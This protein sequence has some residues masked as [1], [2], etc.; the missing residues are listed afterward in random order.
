ME[1][2]E[3][4]LQAKTKFLLRYKSSADASIMFS[5]D[6]TALTSVHLPSTNDV[7]TTINAGTYSSAG[8]GLHT[9]R[10]TVAAGTP[11][12]NYFV[13]VGEEN[14]N[15]AVG[16]VVNPVG[17]QLSVHVY[18]N[19]YTSGSLSFLLS[20]FE[21]NDKVMVTITNPMGKT[22]FKQTR[23]NSSFFEEDLSDVL[24]ESIYFIT[25]EAGSHRIVKKLIVN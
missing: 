13:R 17:E 15:T 23:N 21:N 11:D 20:G 25:V 12:V 14:I 3:L 4:P 18:P 5:V 1:W 8:N 16:E 19:P 24:K 9:V 22:V 7:W 10:L 6:G 2:K